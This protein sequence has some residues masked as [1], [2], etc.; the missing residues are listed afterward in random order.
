MW[1]R[2][3]CGGGRREGKMARWRTILIVL[4]GVASPAT[5]DASPPRLS[6]ARQLQGNLR[7]LGAEHA[8][9]HAGEVGGGKHC[10]G[11]TQP[12]LVRGEHVANACC[13][14]DGASLACIRNELVAFHCWITGN[15]GSL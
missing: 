10:Q 7:G 9:E 8:A 3:L 4:Q 6:V 12:N 11:G 14:N 2:A 1:Q 15:Y 13:A 5:D